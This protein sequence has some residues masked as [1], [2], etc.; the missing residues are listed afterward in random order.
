MFPEK[1]LLFERMFIIFTKN[2]RHE[3]FPAHQVFSCPASYPAGRLC[4]DG[5]SGVHNLS[6]RFWQ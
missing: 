3:S 1:H 2:Q 4:S 6:F 5:N